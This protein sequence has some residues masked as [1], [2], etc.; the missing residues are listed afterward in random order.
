MK[1][2]VIIMLLAI[3]AS[4]GSALWFLAKDDHGSARMLMALKV[5]VAL[6]VLL[7]GFLVLA[8]IQG[9]LQAGG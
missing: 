5:R 3:V 8:Y 2:L 1:L 7:I 6:S 4:L 9:W